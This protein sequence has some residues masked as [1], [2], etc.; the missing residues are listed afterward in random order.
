MQHSFDI[1]IAI[2]YGVNSAVLLNHIFYWVKKNEAN[3]VNYHDGYYWT[4][5]SKKAFSTLFPYM[6]EKQIGYALK[7][8]IDD[9][10]IIT[11]NYNEQPTDR[12]LWYAITD[13]GFE[14]ICGIS[15]LPKM[16]GCI[17]QNCQMEKTIV[18]NGKDNSVKSLYDI[19]IY[20]TNIKH[21]DINTNIKQDNIEKNN[22]KEKYPFSEIIDYLNSKAHTNYRATTEK[23]KSLIRAR[24]NEGFTTDDFKSVIDKKCRTWLN[25]DYEKYL[26]PE[27]LFG[28]KFEAYLQEPVKSYNRDSHGF[29]KN[30]FSNVEFNFA[31]S[32]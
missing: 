10:I 8:L 21:T 32:I 29:E 19:N 2:K 30:D 13:K 28:T 22:K 15:H 16:D 31:N 25:N 18:S 20:N 14:L 12:T 23:T 4:F 5:N 6:S 26:R 24:I 11:G 17:G 27:T 7:T 3:N 1:E 9:G